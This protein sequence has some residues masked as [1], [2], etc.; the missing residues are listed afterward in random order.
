MYGIGRAVIEEWLA[1][2]VRVGAETNSITQVCSSGLF[3]FR[4]VVYVGIGPCGTYGRG[5]HMLST[6]QIVRG[7]LSKVKQWVEGNAEVNR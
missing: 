3:S 6:K 1:L 7:S 5:N 4:Q 2:E